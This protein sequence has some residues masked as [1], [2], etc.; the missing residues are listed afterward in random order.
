MLSRLV[1]DIH[2]AADTENP[3]AAVMEKVGVALGAQSSFLFSSHSRERR[4]ALLIGHRLDDDLVRDF[5]TIWYRKDAWAESA[6]RQGLMKAGVVVTGEQLVPDGQ[7]RRTEFYNEF[8]RPANMG[9]MLGSVLFDGKEARS[10]LPFTNLCWYRP[11][12][13]ASFGNRERRVLQAIL[14]QLQWAVLLDDQRQQLGRQMAISE[15][16]SAGNHA[17]LLIDSSGQIVDMNERAGPL[18]EGRRPFI[19]CRNGHIQTLGERSAP[20]FSDAAAYCQVTGN[21]VR[22]MVQGARATD[23]VAGTLS[24]VTAKTAY[25]LGGSQRSLMLL[26]LNL[27]ARNYADAAR[28]AGELFGLSAAETSVLAAI[29]EGLTVEEIAERRCASIATVRTQVKQIL[30]KS[31]HVRQVDLIRLLVPL[32]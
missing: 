15:A 22:I 26:V 18:L 5:G 29:L 20:G 31:G 14:P 7:L 23:L 11:P 8:C 21:P 32:A 6:A 2:N 27:E 10:P 24:K 9:S 12:G 28:R 19:K 16:Q 25:R 1:T 4:E 13:R 30:S 17:V 3:L